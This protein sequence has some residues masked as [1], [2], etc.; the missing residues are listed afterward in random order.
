MGVRRTLLTA[1]LVVVAVVTGMWVRAWAQ[2]PTV[3]TIVLAMVGGSCE[4]TIIG[5][6]PNDKTKIH[7]KYNDIV[8]WKV[9]NNNCPD[10][11]E[12]V[13]RD[14][15]PSLPVS[16]TLSCKA[17]IGTGTCPINGKVTVRVSTSTT[18]SYAVWV[19]GHPSGD[20]DLII[21]P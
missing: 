6:D 10:K 18:Y 12:V 2:G 11:T 8:R 1:G 14:W 19:A 5:N 3:G 16:G 9:V 17:S 13:L 21:D 20:P 7:A 15:S 4:K